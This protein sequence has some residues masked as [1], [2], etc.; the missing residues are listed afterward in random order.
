MSEWT[1]YLLTR[2]D[3]LRCFIEILM[4]A[5]LVSCVLMS[6]VLAAAFLIEEV[7]ST[8]FLT[9]FKPWFGK[10]L[11]AMLL[12]GALLVLIP[13][14]KELAAIITIP[15]VVNNQDVKAITDNSLGILRE[16][17]AAWL[18][19]MQTEAQKK[20]KEGK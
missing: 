11:N 12:A 17:T 15:A 9:K 16:Q 14:T 20:Q 13:T 6:A 19:E 2:V 10:A 7:D 4:W 8:M 3:S 1:M 5:A 18:R